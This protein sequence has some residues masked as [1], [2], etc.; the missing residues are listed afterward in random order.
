MLPR[1]LFMTRP[2]E[3]GEER[4]EGKERAKRKENKESKEWTKTEKQQQNYC[5]VPAR[6]IT[7]TTRSPYFSTWTCSLSVQRSDVLTA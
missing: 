2:R 7:I 3:E 5:F 4:E 6:S 1:Q